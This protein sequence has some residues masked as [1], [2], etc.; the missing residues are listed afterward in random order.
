ML[1]SELAFTFNRHSSLESNNE[2]GTLRIRSQCGHKNSFDELCGYLY[3]ATLGHSPVRFRLNEALQNLDKFFKALI[4][5]KCNKP[6]VFLTIGQHHRVRGHGDIYYFPTP[7][8]DLLEIVAELCVVCRAG[9]R[10]VGIPLRQECGILR[11]R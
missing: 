1:L 9:L 10:L 3:A 5:Q 11:R 8:L 4:F 7:I 6:L 2:V